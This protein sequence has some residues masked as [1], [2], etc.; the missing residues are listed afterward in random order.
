MTRRA[1]FSSRCS[2]ALESWQ[3]LLSTMEMV[4]EAR[5]AASQVWQFLLVGLD[6]ASKVGH[7]VG[8]PYR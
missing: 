6:E 7:C 4:W 2:L 1:S 3:R 8:E 5:K